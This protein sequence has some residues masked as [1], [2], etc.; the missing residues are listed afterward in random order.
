[1]IKIEP[2]LAT[3]YV[4]VRG[5]LK[6]QPEFVPA[7]NFCNPSDFFFRG[8]TF[9]QHWLPCQLHLVTSVYVAREDGVVLGII[10]LRALGKSKTCWEIDHLLVH[11]A[12]RGRGIAQELLRYAFAQYGSQGV[13]HFISEVSD[14]N[15]AAL[16]LFAAC[17]FCRC[18]KSTHYKLE[19]S[20]QLGAAASPSLPFRLAT[21]N[22][23]HALFQL[24]QDALPPD[25]RQIFAYHPDDFAVSDT[26]FE[27][28]ERL[29]RKFV[30]KR[31]WYWVLEDSERRTLTCA[32][33]VTAHS[34]GDFHLTFAVHP[35]WTQH[36]AELVSHCLQSLRSTGSTTDIPWPTGTRWIAMARVFDFDSSLIEAIQNEGME[37][38]GGFCL[39]SREHWLRAKRPNKIKERSKG[40]P[41][42]GNPVI[43]FP[44]ATD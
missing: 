20:P 5:L 19:F 16:S 10:A 21:P 17:G 15:A 13:S 1:M 26:A 30:R 14:Q 18:A 22:D 6:H 41:A 44:L 25:I 4:Q 3:D 36:A 24:Y 28:M 7:E 23:K 35:G 38:T 2:L 11:P 39:L 43:N 32:V 31:V 33:K 37:R 40:I 42:I 8:L 12:H 34:E 29:R 27:R 9:W